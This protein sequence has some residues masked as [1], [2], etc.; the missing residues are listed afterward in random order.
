MKKLLVT[1]YNMKDLSEVKTIIRW[2]VTRDPATRIMKIDQSAFI[3]DL[4]IKEGLTDCNANIIL[5]KTG[6][7]IKM[8]KLDNYDKINNHIYQ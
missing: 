8:S 7:A 4:L 5:M 2:Q 1:E 3:R 6:S